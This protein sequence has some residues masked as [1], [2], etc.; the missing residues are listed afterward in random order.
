MSDSDFSAPSMSFI[1][2]SGIDVVGPMDQVNGP[3]AASVGGAVQQGQQMLS[4]SDKNTPPGPPIFKWDKYSFCWNAYW[5]TGGFYDGTVLRKMLVEIDDQYLIR[6]ALTFYRNFFRQIIDATFKP[7]FAVSATRSTQVNGVVDK[8]GKSCP[9][10]N[11]FQDDCDNR[12]RKI[13]EFTKKVV[14]GA[15]ITGA[16]F[17]VM[18]NFPENELPKNTPE[19]IKSRKFPYVYTRLPQQVEEKLVVINEF[20]QI[21]E[22]AFR[23]N[24]EKVIDLQG[25]TETEKRWKKW[26]RS[27][28]VKMRQDKESRDIVEIPDTLRLHNLGEVPVIP[29]I[30]SEAEDDTLLPQP[31][32]YDICRCNWAIYNWDSFEARTICASMYPI[33]TLPQPQGSNPN[34]GAQAMSPTQGLYVAPAENGTTPAHP[35]YLDYPTNCFEA[36]Q[37]YISELIDDM[38]RQAGQLGVQAQTGGKPASGLSKIADFH[39]QHFVLKESAKMAK[40]AEEEMARI[41]QLYYISEKF[42]FEAHYE[43]D[44][45]PDQDVDADVQL[46]GD[47]MALQPG[48]KGR[49]LALKMATLSVF[50]DAEDDDVAEVIADIDQN[51]IDEE[52]DDQDIMPRGDGTLTPEQIAE[53]D[54]QKKADEAA[55]QKEADKNNS[56]VTPKK[57]KK[58]AK[59]GYS[60]KK[61]KQ[62]S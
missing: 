14:K 50:D 41:F 56:P 30:P 20:C 37:K 39:A 42:D 24:P 53:A 61:Q 47:Y 22:I 4:G 7:V 15:R 59:R 1:A 43:E 49:A 48:K 3:V 16:S 25:K 2:P 23:E 26:T 18:D 55:T 21:E 32:F 19:V 13:G 36:V 51:M 44:Y 12:H 31:A 10:W 33:L 29:V 58:V 57:I 34:A 62:G 35:M 9:V 6:R 28:S 40:K 60:L 17:I 5:G 52:K 11:K 27:Y 45:A 54:A 46:Y 38:F 8:D